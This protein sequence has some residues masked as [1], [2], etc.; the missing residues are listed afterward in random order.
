LEAHISG[1]IPTESRTPVRATVAALR[2]RL[3]ARDHAAAVS[4]ASKGAL[5]FS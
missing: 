1:P 2:K 4:L 5:M 3:S